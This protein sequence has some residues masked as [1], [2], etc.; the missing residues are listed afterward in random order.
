MHNAAVYGHNEIAELLIANG[1][2]VNAK[3]VD[4]LTP[5]DFAIMSN[6]PEIADLLRKHS[7]KTKKELEAAGN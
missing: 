6:Q 7:G 1:A 5:L 2:N 4:G 3:E